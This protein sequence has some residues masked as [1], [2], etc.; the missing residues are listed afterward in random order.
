MADYKK[1]STFD[2]HKK[3]PFIKELLEIEVTKRRKILAG[4][5]P[6][7]IVNSETG[8]VEGHQVFAITEKVDKEKFI[9]VYEQGLTSLFNVSKSGLK[10]FAFLTKIAKPNKDYVIF[11]IDDC[12]EYTG[13]KTDKPILKGIAELIEGNLIARSRYHF[14]YFINPSMFFNGNRYTLIQSYVLDTGINQDNLINPNST[15]LIENEK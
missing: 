12:K 4:K 10:V 9:K 13:Y 1:V 15:K 5:S 2:K 14:K 8:E 3:S 6:N 11:E 7:I